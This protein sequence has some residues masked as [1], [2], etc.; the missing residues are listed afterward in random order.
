MLILM[1]SIS[2][3][4]AVSIV[5]KMARQQQIQ[6]AQAIAFNYVMASFLTVLLLRP[7]PSS[8]LSAS[9]TSYG[10]VLALGV[11]LPSVF[12]IMAKAVREV[13]IVLTDAAQRLS[14][15][16]PLLAAI[17][18][19]GEVL[20][21]HKLLGMLLGIGALLC[22]S[23]GSKNNQNSHHSPAFIWLL[24]TWIGF[25][26]IDVLFKQLS[27]V[28]VGF[29]SSLLVVFVLAGLLLFGWLLAQGT[30]W[31]A[32]SAAA[33]LLLG[34]LNFGNI[35]FYLRAHQAFPENPT[36]V[37]STMNIGVITLGTLVGAVFFKEKLSRVSVI[38]I[39][40]ALGAIVALI[41]R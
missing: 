17:V 38:G 39:A 21:A 24:G 13:G 23:F 27:K 22:L 12:L 8:L 5:L 9:S 7:E 41:P 32:R 6:V 14:L 20:V 11:L 37:F 33:G 16:I 1:M 34:L 31:Q 10:V 19:F 30:K 3:S 28:G 25:G 29:S 18:L 26:I 36:L 35:Y 40:L 15:V 4:V 2:C